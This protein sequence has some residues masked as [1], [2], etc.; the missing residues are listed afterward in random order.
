MGPKDKERK[1]ERVCVRDRER[2]KQRKR[3]AWV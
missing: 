1:G 3:W 2:E